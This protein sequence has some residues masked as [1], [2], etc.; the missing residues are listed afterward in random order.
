MATTVRIPPGGTWFDTHKKSFV[1][2]SVDPKDQGI[3]TSEFLDAAEST[4]TLFGAILG[5]FPP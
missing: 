2:V 4:A 3:A 1:E 5:C